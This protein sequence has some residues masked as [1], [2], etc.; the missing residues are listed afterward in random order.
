MVNPTLLFVSLDGSES[1]SRIW[2]TK[3]TSKRPECSKLDL[4]SGNIF[5]SYNGHSASGTSII[6]RIS[7]HNLTACSSDSD[8]RVFLSSPPLSDSI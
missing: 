5:Q 1:S 8:K 4:M 6:M 2:D 7:A 3:T